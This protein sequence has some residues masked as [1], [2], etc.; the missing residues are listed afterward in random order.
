MG[1]DTTSAQRNS[2]A[3]N[4]RDSKIII[5]NVDTE[6]AQ[7]IKNLIIESGIRKEVVE[8]NR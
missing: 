6:T 5:Q 8:Y 4:D 3:D 2:S 1:A 7:E